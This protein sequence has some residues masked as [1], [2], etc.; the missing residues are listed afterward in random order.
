M[1]IQN[2]IKSRIIAKS[3]TCYTMGCPCQ[4]IHNTAHQCSTACT[5]AAQFE[6][7]DF[8]VDMFY[9]FDKSTKR[10]CALK[11]CS[12][13]WGQEYKQI[14]KHIN[15]WWLSVERAVER[16]LKQYPGLH[17][18]FLSEDTPATGGNSEWGGRKTCLRLKNAFKHP[19]TEIYP[20]FFSTVLP[21]FKTTNI[22]LHLE[23]LYILLI[24]D[25]LNCFLTN[26]VGR[27]IP[28][29]TFKSADHL[30]II[31]LDNH[32]HPEDM[33]LGLL[34]KSTLNKLF[35]DGTISDRQKDKFLAGVH[36]F[37][38]KSF[39]Y[40]MEKL[41]ID[42]P[43]LKNV[44]FVDSSKRE[45]VD[46][47]NVSFFVERFDLNMAASAVNKLSEEFLDHQLIDGAEIPY[48]VWTEATVKVEKNADN[49]VKKEFY[50]MDV[51]WGYL[52][53]TIRKSFKGCKIDFGS[54]S[55]QCRKGTSI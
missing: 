13:F 9:Y 32:K 52:T 19:M 7:E 37:Y 25:A 28:V 49:D 20:M 38:E 44:V 26:L 34:T 15:V 54:S 12:E 8:C 35:E 39:K 17:S 31:N 41:S 55:F 51:L 23:D 48:P 45:N 16:I 18:Y 6:I 40:D 27:F 22:L 24:H 10:K 42:D 11:A 47:D 43:V 36:A 46:L 29:C 3:E 30:F 33:Y 14:L 4:I 53:V 50:R 1:G 5:S 21:T 2:S